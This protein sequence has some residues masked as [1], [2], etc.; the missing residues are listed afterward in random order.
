MIQ[1]NKS[2]SKFIFRFALFGTLLT[3]AQSGIA[4]QTCKGGY[5]AIE[6]HLFKLATLS[7]K[8]VIDNQ[9]KVT[10]D[11]LN[12]CQKMAAS[13]S[14]DE[15]KAFQQAIRNA[16]DR[17]AAMELEVTKQA[18][19]ET[20][21]TR[22]ANLKNRAD[23]F[24][25]LRHS[26][27]AAYHAISGPQPIDRGW[28]RDFIANF[29]L[30]FE[31]TSVASIEEKGTTRTGMMVYNQVSNE[32]SEEK[33]SHHIFGNVLL[34]S[35]AEQST[36]TDSGAQDNA[37]VEPTIEMDLNYY[38]PKIITKQSIGA[39]TGGPIFKLGIRKIDEQTG[40]THKYGL[41][42]RFAHSPESFFDITL[43][44]T[45]DVDGNRLEISGQ[46][47]VAELFDGG[48]FVGSL[49]NLGVG[50]DRS[51]ESDTLRLYVTWQVSFTDIFG[52][53]K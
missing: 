1:K 45:E 7:D 11:H 48:V 14:P 40:F 9:I 19:A 46:L 6:G 24:A 25:A 38:A 21:T 22:I 31:G 43:G 37:S 8:T 32:L 44:E 36:A 4:N 42:L 30:G 50:S 10:T 2:I 16:A 3:V 35:S 15:R 20:D 49:I 18:L 29:Y 33:F 28:G 41:G 23:K 53:V 5:Q 52:S 17:T 39:F 12:E 26:M 27:Q 47:P 13:L 34:T 51:D